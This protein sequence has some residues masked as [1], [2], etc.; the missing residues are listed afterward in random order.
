MATQA[1]ASFTSN[2][3]TSSNVHPALSRQVWIAPTGAIVKSFGSCAWAAWATMRATGFSPFASATDWRVSTMAAAPSEIELDVAAVIVPSLAKAGRRLGILSGRPLP[4][5]SSVSTVTSPL[6]VAK[7]T[8]VI[9]VA[10]APL[11]IAFCA[12]DSDSRA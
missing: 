5:C 7:V 3:S 12:R 6:R 8:G 10:N 9:S 11:S 1:K 2:R 4:G